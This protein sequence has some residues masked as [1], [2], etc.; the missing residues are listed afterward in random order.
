[1]LDLIA[2][3]LSGEELRALE[4]RTM[5]DAWRQ[6]GG[7]D[8]HDLSRDE[9]IQL[10]EKLR[11]GKALL[12]DVVGTPNRLVLTVS[13]L[14][15]P[16]GKQL[17]RISVEGPPDSLA[18]LVN[19]I[20]TQLMTQT[21]GETAARLSTLT[22]TSLPA[23][24]AYLDGQARLRRGDAVTA[25]KDFE[26]ALKE[27][28]TFALAGLGLR[29]ATSW[30]GDGQLGDRGL[31]IAV[32]EKA[33]LSPRDQLLLT[34]LAGPK[35]PDASTNRE[36]YAA[37]EQFLASA[38]D[39]AEA[40]YLVADHIFHFG[41]AMGMADWE[42]RSLAGFKKAME[43]DSL[44]LP[45]YNHAL[46]LAPSLGDTEF[47]NRA[48]RL[49]ARADTASFWRKQH[50]YYMAARAGEDEAA[51]NAL[52][53]NGLQREGLLQGV[54]RHVQ[55]DGTGA[56][57]AQRAIEEIVRT[58][59]TE[60]LRRGRSRYA[61]DVM[62]NL[63]RP[64]QAVTYLNA[65]KDSADDFNVRII[66]VRDAIAGEGSRALADEAAVALADLENGP[67]PAD[68]TARQ[69]QRAVIRVLEP[70]RL[71]KG[72]TSQTRRSL[73]RLRSIARTSPADQLSQSEL[74]IAYIEMLHAGLTRAPTLRTATERVDSMLMD[75]NFGGVHT[76]RTTQHA[77]ATAH[78]WERLSEPK[79][80]LSAVLRYATWN[81]EV[82]PYLGT[83]VREIARIAALAGDRKRA[84][85]S[86]RHYLGLRSLAEPSLKPQVDSVRRE[87]SALESRG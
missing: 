2:A 85:R 39:N 72:D 47:T 16:D 40:W 48:F 36:L 60:A 63:G 84:L 51:A 18:S 86:Y 29:L 26:R 33:R 15:V 11:A 32:R 10:A 58:S 21:S 61:H 54:I 83:Q 87:L 52:A 79:R 3:K 59:A 8:S 71:T 19:Q 14:D 31:A 41:A 55:F 62:M 53:S 5:L 68:S 23:L 1:M 81:T 70:W 27:D 49:H 20:A 65:S 42:E 34:A 73:A 37:R 77:I 56:V 75:Q 24:R 9:T 57:H 76:G 43:L 17:S 46:P 50:Q 64:A 30:Y 74:E 38:P 6:A 13:L 44:Y 4:P 12:G 22:S 66:L 25:A 69:I 67:E 45:G 80:A 35:Y 28:S 7:T 78:M 82:M